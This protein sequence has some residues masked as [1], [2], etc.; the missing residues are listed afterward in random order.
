M[1]DENTQARFPQFAAAQ[2]TVV[3]LLREPPTNF[4][5]STRQ[6]ALMEARLQLQRALYDAVEYE[7]QRVASLEICGPEQMRDLNS[8]VKQ[9]TAEAA[10]VLK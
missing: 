8:T 6:V 3:Q 9:L 7:M 5:E 1:L 2:L 10:T 4:S